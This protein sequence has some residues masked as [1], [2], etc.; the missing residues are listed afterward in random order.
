MVHQSQRSWVQ[1]PV[2]ALQ[3]RSCLPPIP[4][5]GGVL[6]DPLGLPLRSSGKGPQVQSLGGYGRTYPLFNKPF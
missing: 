3:R 2:P 6:S 4:A 1:L 5:G